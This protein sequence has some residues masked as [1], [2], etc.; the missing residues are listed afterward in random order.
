MEI[1]LFLFLIFLLLLLFFKAG[2]LC[3]AFWSLSWICSV[4]QVDLKL[5]EIRLL[6][7]PKFWDQKHASSSPSGEKTFFINRSFVFH[8]SIISPYTYHLTV[9]PIFLLL[10][11]QLSAYIPTYPFI[12][13][14]VFLPT[15]LSI[16]IFAWPLYFQ[17]S[18][19]T[20]STVKLFSGLL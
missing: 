5:K 19:A 6:L 8:V 12:Y 14:S 3:V 17:Q 10:A 16:H 20:S 18:D 4:D 1:T 15:Y 11:Y 2:F 13:S 7:S 9:Q